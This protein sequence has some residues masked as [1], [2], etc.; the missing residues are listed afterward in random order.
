MATGAAFLL[1]VGYLSFAVPASQTRWQRLARRLGPFGVAL[2]LLPYL[3]VVG[4]RPT[5]VDLRHWV[6]FLTVPTVLRWGLRRDAFWGTVLPA[7]AL[8]YALEP[9][10]FFLPW[11]GAPV[12]PLGW[13]IPPDLGAPLGGLTLPV[14]KLTGVWLALY[15]FVAYR[16]LEGVGFTVRLNQND[17]LRALHGWA[18]FALVG[19]PVGWV[20]GFLRWTPRFPGWGEAMV[21]LLGGYLLV[22]LPE[23]LLFRGVLQNAF[24]RRWPRWGLPL[25]AVVFGLSHL[26]NATPGFPVPNGAYALM[27]TLAGLAYGW[28]WQHTRK[29]S[30]SAVT[31]AL[32]NGMWAWFFGG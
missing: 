8:W 2:G 27:A 5:P 21:G 15:L 10:L 19:V 32:V 18:L 3:L 22:A 29:V 6:L 9:D 7:L 12:G 28:V 4:F 11:G 1:I 20:L 26:N 23:E 30:A 17:G 13:F 24:A 16:P 25:A 14:T 31:H